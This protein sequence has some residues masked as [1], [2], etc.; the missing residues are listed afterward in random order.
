[1]AQS[2]AAATAATA[3]PMA[4][5]VISIRQN[6][7][8]PR[9]GP[10]VFGPTGDGYR[11][12]GAPLLLAM[13]AAYIPQT[14]ASAFMPNQIK[15]LPDW[16]MRDA[17]DIDAKVSDQDL[18]AWQ[19]PAKQKTMLP[20]MM[21]ALFQDRFKMAVHREIKET[22]VYWLVVGKG[23]PKFKETDPTAEHP[24]GTTLPW[25]GTLVESNGSATL[26][27]TS[28]ES[29]ATLLSSIGGPNLGRAV[30]DKTG[31]TGRYD[32]TIKPPNNRGSPD[33]AGGA[34]DPGG[35]P[36]AMLYSV[37]DSLGLKLES[38]KSTVETLV[39]DHIER[40]SAN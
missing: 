38:G 7:S 23:G 34:S 32:V 27:G 11:M 10:P 2:Q 8:P 6:L 25:G 9:N 1:M 40:P 21:Q 35:G 29:L 33:Q 20:P 17:Y 24:D 26:Y 36:T 15:G 5:D 31:L 28:M 4:F 30:Q 13:M 18:A 37:V 12:V 3:K 14:G 16:A 22:D 19:D 39:I